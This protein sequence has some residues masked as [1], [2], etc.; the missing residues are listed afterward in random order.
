MNPHYAIIIPAYNEEALLGETLA[1]IRE[2]MSEI[3]EKGELIVVDNNSTDR[4]GEV[5]GE[6]GADKVVFEPHN[7]IARA[8]NAGAAATEAERLVFID[9][10]T[11]IEAGTLSQALK[12]LESGKIAAGGARIVMDQAVIPIVGWL[13][14]NWNR[15]GATFHYAAGSFFYCRRDAFEAGGGFDESVYAGEEVWLAKRIKKWARKEKLR[16]VVIQNPPVLTSGRKSDWFSTWD[17]VRQLAIIFLIPG[18]TRSR[19]MCRVWYERPE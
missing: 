14:D 7:Q 1:S 17:F 13:T 6:N 12:N 16:F 18:S 19:K 8:R 4:T 5:A 11:R 2:A 9:A 10:D 15:V 3:E